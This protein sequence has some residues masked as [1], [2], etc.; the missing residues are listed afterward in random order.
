MNDSRY[1]VQED[2]STG[3]WLCLADTASDKIFIY[4]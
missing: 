3:R 1:G 2:F 4:I